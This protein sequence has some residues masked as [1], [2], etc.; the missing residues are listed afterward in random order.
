[1]TLITIKIKA[2][3]PGFANERAITLIEIGNTFNVCAQT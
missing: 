3:N 1:M 2:G